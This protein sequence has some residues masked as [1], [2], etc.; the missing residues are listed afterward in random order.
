MTDSE[1]MNVQDEIEGEAE[2]TEAEMETREQEEMERRQEGAAELEEIAERMQALLGEAEAVVR[3]YGTPS[4]LARAEA[5]WLPNIQRLIAGSR[6][7][8]SIESTINELR[9]GEES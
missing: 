8:V 1:M 6:H 2:L 3:E 5:Y 9:E 4:E 7:E